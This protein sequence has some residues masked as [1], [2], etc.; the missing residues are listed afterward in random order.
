[1]GSSFLSL[2]GKSVEL[3]LVGATETKKGKVLQVFNHHIVFK[4]NDVEEVI[5]ILETEIRFAKCNASS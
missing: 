2:V 3:L 1:M 4:E 5:Y